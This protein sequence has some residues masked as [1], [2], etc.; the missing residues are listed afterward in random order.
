MGRD[1]LHRIKGSAAPQ[2][3]A[4]A[5]IA[6]PA[7]EL[8]GLR[9]RLCA[10]LS[11][12]GPVR[13]PVLG[14]GE[15]LDVAVAVVAG[16]ERD[17]A[18]EAHADRRLRVA[19]AQCHPLARPPV[20]RYIAIM[21]MANLASLFGG[22]TPRRP[23]SSDDFELYPTLPVYPDR[24]LQVELAQGHPA[25]QVSLEHVADIPGNAVPVVDGVDGAPVLPY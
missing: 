25:E 7:A 11:R 10:L 12:S 4:H 2:A 19:V 5:R 14:A 6:V 18:H 15:K 17:I 13:R 3:G 20:A 8:D 24:G 1:L 23:R 16:F 21:M 9:N 22:A